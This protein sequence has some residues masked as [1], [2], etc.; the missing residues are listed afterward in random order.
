MATNASTEVDVFSNDYKLENRRVT[1]IFPAKESGRNGRIIFVLDGD[2][3]PTITPLGE[4][5][6]GN[7]ISFD[8]TQIG[9]QFG[10]IEAIKLAKSYVGIGVI[11]FDI[12]SVALIDS[13]ISINRVFK[14]KGEKREGG[15]DVYSNDCFTSKVTSVIEPNYGQL[16]LSSLS[17]SLDEMR[18]EVRKASNSLVE[19]K[20]NNTNVSLGL[21]LVW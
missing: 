12:I 19:E 14:K 8:V 21:K 9:K 16:T 20:K 17:M 7:T 13:I 10:T 4:K 18:K 11:P 5:K 2:P 6:M 1:D 15:E 3:F